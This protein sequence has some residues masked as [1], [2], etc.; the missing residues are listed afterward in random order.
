[1]ISSN[2][3]SK[4]KLSGEETIFVEVSEIPYI[5]SGE[6]FITVVFI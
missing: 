4:E 6:K 5:V 3:E 2:K 1:M